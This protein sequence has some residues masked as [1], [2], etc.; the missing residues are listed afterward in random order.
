VTNNKQ[1]TVKFHEV[2]AGGLHFDFSEKTGELNAH[3]ADILGER[4]SFSTS[5]DIKPIDTQMVHV[6]GKLTGEMPQVCSRC[7]EEYQLPFQK[8]F[9][10]AYYKSEDN[11]R[12]LGGAINDLDG[13]FDIEFLDGNEIN[14]AD[15]IHEQVAIE[16]PFKPLCSEECLG[17]CTRCGINLNFSKC[18]CSRDDLKIKNSPFEKLKELR[19]E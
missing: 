8:K 12:N 17:L 11:I 3:L 2:P 16:I 13:S 15:L 1:L 7:A 18:N 9:I 6:E 5:M 19:G 14:L 10:T 4:P